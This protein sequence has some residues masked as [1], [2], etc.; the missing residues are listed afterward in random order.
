M[1]G[2]NWSVRPALPAVLASPRSHDDVLTDDL[3]RPVPSSH[4]TSLEHLPRT[5]GQRCLGK[6]TRKID[7]ELFRWRRKPCINSTRQFSLIV[8]AR[9][10]RYSQCQ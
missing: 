2:L 4:N 6:A 10:L 8:I 9:S 3:A 5:A 1:T 7:N